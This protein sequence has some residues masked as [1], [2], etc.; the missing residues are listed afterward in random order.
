MLY[1]SLFLF[2]L[3]PFF[4][5]F[6]FSVKRG[7]R[8][9]FILI[10]SLVFIFLFDSRAVI[11]IL[12]S[13]TVNYLLARLIYRKKRRIFFVLSLLFN[14]SLLAL[15]KYIPSLISFVGIDRKAS[16]PLGISFYTFSAISYL[17]D[18]FKNRYAPEKNFV[19]FALWLSFFPTVFAGPIVR[20]SQ[21]SEKIISRRES[22]E[23]FSSGISRFCIGLSKKLILADS[24][25]SLCTVYR[26]SAEKDLL[27]LL[28]F[29]AAYTLYIYY[30]F[31]G[32]S[33]M[34][35]G[36]SLMIGFEIP[37]NFNYPY[38]SKSVSEFFRRW[39]ITLSL[40]FR[41]YVYI[42][43]GGN[44]V[45]FLRHIMNILCVW[46]LT[47]LWHGASLPFLLWGIYFG[48]I[49]IFEKYVFSKIKLPSFVSHVSLILTVS[50][51]F[52][53]FS[54]ESLSSFLSD[55]YILSGRAGIFSDVSLYYLK[56][57]FLLLIISSVG[58]TPLIK[59]LFGLLYERVAYFDLVAKPLL[60][61]LSLF[62]CTAFSVSGSFTPLLY[63]NF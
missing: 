30:D 1:T 19:S 22:A 11:L 38:I 55:L 20:Y 51:G 3:L 57:S 63:A 12:F 39:H 10:F 16:L 14:L 23:L 37:E 6:Y 25:F 34:A 33:D 42:P 45:S 47:G 44:R 49:L 60:V 15:Y 8:N 2:F 9:L 27:F 28:I 26:G 52:L 43:L 36:V 4:L 21:I 35:I 59:K 29:I 13:I 62:L 32:Y 53:I 17:S 56:G 31:S 50:F 41:D 7:Y 5:F 61:L 18:V 24:L 54:S 46:L 58:A 48:V 40:F